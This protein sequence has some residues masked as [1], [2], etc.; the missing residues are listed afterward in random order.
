MFS[1]L[2]KYRC[3]EREQLSCCVCSTPAS[4]K[5]LLYLCRVAPYLGIFLGEPR[6]AEPCCGWL[7]MSKELTSETW[8]RVFEV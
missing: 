7:T 2:R 6:G 1:V 4:E 3:G 5:Y 8:K